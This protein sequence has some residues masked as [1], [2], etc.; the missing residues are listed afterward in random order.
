MYPTAINPLE[1]CEVADDFVEPALTTV[2]WTTLDDGGT[3]TDLMN[4]VAG[5]EIAVVTA[6]AANDYHL[7]FGGKI[8]LPAAAK[9]IWFAAR[10]KAGTSAGMQYLG[11]SSDVTATIASDT[12]GVLN[13][14]FSACMFYCLPASLALG[15]C[16]SNAAVQTKQ[17]ALITQVAA[18]YY[19][20]GF[21]VDPGDGTTAIV[22][23]WAYDE[24]AGTRT[25][26]TPQLLALASLAQMAVIFGVKSAGAAETI[27]VDY[28]R[29]AQKR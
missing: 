22:T 21:H 26:G 2:R 12:T 20:V 10:F 5:G 16:S 3:G 1:M 6:A 15:F 23:P 18:Q 14:S 25:V 29:C 11:L 4:A 9:P 19:Q 27:K 24:T 7:L 8:F 13:T 28:I 17:A